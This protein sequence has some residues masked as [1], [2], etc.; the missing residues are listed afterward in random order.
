MN[1][2]EASRRSGLPAKTIRYYEGV[3]LVGPSGRRANNYRD[4]DEDDVHRLVFVQR[5][6]GLG[7]TLD[8]C[9][10]LLGLYA[11]RDRTSAQVKGLALRRIEEIEGRIRDLEAMRAALAELARRC[12]GDDRPAC[13]ILEGL[14]GDQPSRR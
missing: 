7:F 10:E 4:Y 11:D 14:A 12:H 8:E 13:P 1:I 3:G 5:A 6:R 9:R 2:G